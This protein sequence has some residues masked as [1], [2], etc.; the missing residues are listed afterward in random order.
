MMRLAPSTPPSFRGATV[1]AFTRVF[2]ALRSRAR[3]PYHWLRRMDSGLAAFA[4]PRND[5]L[6]A[7]RS[8]RRTADAATLGLGASLRCTLPRDHFAEIRN[9]GRGLVGRQVGT[10][11][12]LGFREAALQADRQRK[13]AAHAR[14][15]GAAG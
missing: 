14:I 11:D 7:T 6:R 13:V 5:R 3:N 1:S 4:A 15:G 12:R 8:A 10:R 2:D 9:V